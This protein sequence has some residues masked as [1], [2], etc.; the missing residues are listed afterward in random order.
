M[1]LSDWSPVDAQASL[2]AQI[3]KNLPGVQETL[4]QSL[5]KGMATH[6][7][8]LAW[9]ILWTE[10]L[11]GLQSM[12]SKRVGHSWATNTSHFTMDGD[13]ENF[14]YL[15]WQTREQ[16]V[17][18][19]LYH[20][21]CV[22]GDVDP[23]FLNCSRTSSWVSTDSLVRTAASQAPPWTCW[24]RIWVLKRC[25]GDLYAYYSLRSTGWKH[26]LGQISKSEIVGSRHR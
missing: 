1:H 5:E 23:C 12:G 8:I 20:W 13:S 7:S 17:P 3:V 25:P 22:W 18:L 14:Q 21:V 10:E 9:R 16:G 11:G 6:S 4:V 26:W 24:I 2:V 15:Q 19:H